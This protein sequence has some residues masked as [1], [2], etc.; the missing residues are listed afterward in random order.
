VT[1]VFRI[2]AASGEASSTR[3]SVI[4]LCWPLPTTS[5]LCFRSSVRPL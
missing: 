5:G 3:R 1:A 4:R 2:A